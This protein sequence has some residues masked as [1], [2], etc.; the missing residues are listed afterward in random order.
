M[1][2]TGKQIRHLRGVAHHSRAIVTVGNLGPGTGVSA[3]LDCALKAHEL[4]KIKLPATSRQEKKILLDRLCADT[5]A[6]PIQLIGRVGV[7]YRP[8]NPPVIKIP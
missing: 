6:I 4:V 1:K 8:A 7:A 5:D 3:E 2:L